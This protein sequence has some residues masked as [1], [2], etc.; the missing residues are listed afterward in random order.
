MVVLMHIRFE[1]RLVLTRL[2]SYQSLDLLLLK[3]GIRPDLAK[4]F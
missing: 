3:S 1:I 2:N 4:R